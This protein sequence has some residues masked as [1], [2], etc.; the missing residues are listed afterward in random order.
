MLELADA[1]LD[2]MPFLIGD[3]VAGAWGDPIPLRR[4]GGDR[5]QLLLD[6]GDR[7]VSVVAPVGEHRPALDAGEQ[8]ERLRIVPRRA[9][10]QE[11]LQRV[12]QRIDQHMDLRAEA[13]ARPP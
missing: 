12:A 10:G 5:P 1:T 2:E 13:A 6:V 9:A 7:R 3:V 8:R 4:D 11:E